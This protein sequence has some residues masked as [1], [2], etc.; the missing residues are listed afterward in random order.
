MT[1]RQKFFPIMPQFMNS[2]L[3]TVLDYKALDRDSN[4]RENSYVSETS[5]SDLF[6]E[7]NESNTRN[8]RAKVFSRFLIDK[9]EAAGQAKPSPTSLAEIDP[10]ARVSL[11]QII[12]ENWTGSR[13]YK[14]QPTDSF[15]LVNSQ[16]LRQSDDLD[17]LEERTE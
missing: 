2:E 7:R 13:I 14:L 15:R 17:A 16:S 5:F 4:K 6:F 11:S 1:F 9:P 12:L 8:L 3:Q 10:K